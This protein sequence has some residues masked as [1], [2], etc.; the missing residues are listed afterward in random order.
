MATPEETNLRFRLVDL[1]VQMKDSLCE[2]FCRYNEAW[3]KYY[4]VTCTY[5]EDDK[6]PVP[7]NIEDLRKCSTVGP[8]SICSK[9]PALRLY[10]VVKHEYVNLKEGFIIYAGNGATFKF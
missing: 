9:F 1:V 6:S 4:N 5:K 8:N 3:W 10:E 2:R 7:V